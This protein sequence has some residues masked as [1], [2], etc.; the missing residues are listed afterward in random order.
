MFKDLVWL[1]SILDAEKNILQPCTPK[2]EPAKSFD[3][4]NLKMY[5]TP[6]ELSQNFQNLLMNHWN[7]SQIPYYCPYKTFSNRKNVRSFEFWDVNFDFYPLLL[8][9]QTKT[10]RPDHQQ[11]RRI[12]L[13]WCA[14]FANIRS[15]IFLLQHHFKFLFEGI[16]KNINQKLTWLSAN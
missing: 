13:F 11:S 16:R 5:W 6:L 7:L 12:E 4:N 3:F 2:T 14:L 1:I 8:H 15:G 9:L 10:N